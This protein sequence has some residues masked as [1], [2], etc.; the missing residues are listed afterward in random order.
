MPLSHFLH[1]TACAWA[2]RLDWIFS[3]CL[4]LIARAD[5]RTAREAT[6]HAYGVY[7]FYEIRGQMAQ[8]AVEGLGSLLDGERVVWLIH[9]STGEQPGVLDR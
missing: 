7:R 6:M 3:S 2:R 9:V 4:P 8:A 5:E 1:C